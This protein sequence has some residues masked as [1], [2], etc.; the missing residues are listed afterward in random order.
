M[1]RRAAFTLVELLV[2][3]AIVALLAA[4]LS[5]SLRR[6]S[7]LARL[8][9]CATN[10]HGIAGG[11]NG[12]A[13]D[14]RGY[15]P[16]RTGMPL[17][18]KCNRLSATGGGD[19]RVLLR[20]HMPLGLLACPL[21]GE[22]YLESDDAE[23]NVYS[24]YDLWF[25]WKIGS[26]GGGRGLTHMDQDMEY[27]GFTFDVLACD[28]DIYN[29]GGAWV[30]GTHPDSDNVMWNEVLGSQAV[31]NVTGPVKYTLSRWIS[32]A[33]NARGTIDRNFAHIDGSVDRVMDVR[34]D[35]SRMVILPEFSLSG[36]DWAVCQ[37]PPKD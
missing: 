21:A 8:G 1:S 10:L 33:T 20:P 2:V 15:Y 34:V 27:A 25:G 11:A 30:H 28:R 12:Y 32:Y 35:D 19:D 5:P 18:W 16:A 14:N 26:A 4:I 6:A 3:V 29:P 9:V 17:G 22:P 23:T 36:L 7:Y 24:T 31:Q 37:L 13:G